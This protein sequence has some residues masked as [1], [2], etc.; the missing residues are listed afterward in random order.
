MINDDDDDL[1]SLLGMALAKVQG[2]DA[3]AMLPTFRKI[4]QR[5][6]EVPGEGEWGYLLRGLVYNGA[7]GAAYAAGQFEEALRFAEAE[8][9]TLRAS[10]G[11]ASYARALNNRGLA[12]LELGN[13]VSAEEDFLAALKV[14]KNPEVQTNSPIADSLLRIIEDHLE[15]VAITRAGGTG[16]GRIYTPS[17]ARHHGSVLQESGVGRLSP[18]RQAR[19]ATSTLEALSKATA[20]RDSGHR[21]EARR[22]LQGIVDEARAQGDPRALG[23][24]LSNLG[25][26][27]LLVDTG[28]AL[29][30]LSESVEV[31]DRIPPPN[32][33]LALAL[34]NL[35]L[36]YQHEE[37]YPS[38]TDAAKKAWLLIHEASSSNPAALTILHNLARL[39][40]LQRDL[41]RARAILQHSISLYDAARARFAVLEQDHEGIFA[42]YRSLVELML[43]VALDGE[44]TDE[45]VSL[46]ENAK[47]RFLSEYLE[48]LR[49]S[50][51]ERSAIPITDAKPFEEESA[52]IDLSNHLA[53]PNTFTIS[54]FTG[55]NFTFVV[56]SQESN[57]GAFRVDIS[58]SELR[59][60]VELFFLDLQSA[61]LGQPWRNSGRDLYS[62]LLG[63]ISEKFADTKLLFVLPDG[64]LWLLP[65]DALLLAAEPVPDR[66]TSV[67]VYSAFSLRTIQQLR[68][69]VP[70]AGCPQRQAVIVAKSVFKNYPELP[71]TIAEAKTVSTRLAQGGFETTTLKGVEATPS[72]VVRSL[73]GAHIVHLATHAVAPSD[74]SESYIVLDDGSGGEA[75]LTVRDIVD[76]RLS[77]RV[78]FLSVC[79]SAAGT[80]SV[81]EGIVSIARAFILTGCQSVIASLWPVVAEDSAILAERFYSTYL[82]V[83]SPAMALHVAK[84]S[85][86]GGGP[87]MRTAAA[88]QLYGDGD[89]RF[90]VRDLVNLV[91]SR[92]DEP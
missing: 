37:D 86:S 19:L 3:A 62:L 7:F 64:P 11:E 8:C 76:L 87:L 70:V 67:P 80:A 28:A 4:A 41:V 65:F 32:Q 52:Q 48:R 74:G 72:R 9:E 91:R 33:P 16:K 21:E 46:I 90:T 85:W 34:H 43:L 49:V 50:R 30:T 10:P 23:I 83:D 12:R 53:S 17:S 61:S 20:A 26:F 89:A 92:S 58:E 59:E 14:L 29:A 35:S 27:L 45:V 71:S 13:L 60:R 40:L 36:A 25:E 79:S 88:F 42:V 15:I 6:D 2:P 44:W 69:L 84:G 75:A 77:A 22:V 24:A 18:A 63:R 38:A 5:I 73:Q 39:R 82:Y 55:P 54:F 56:W 31:L 1:G 47:A 51:S 78:V 66:T 68:S 57:R 81:G